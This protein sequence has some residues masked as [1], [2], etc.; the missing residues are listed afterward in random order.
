[1]NEFLEQ[2]LIEGRELV[3]QATEDLLVLEEAPDDRG[4]L[5]SAFR[6]FH[7]LKGLA[8]IVEFAAM[9]RVMHTA[10]DGLAAP[11]QHVTA[12]ELVGR[13]DIAALPRRPWVLP[14]NLQRS[15]S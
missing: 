7:T 13:F 2:F 4:R 6:G 5:D 11:G 1:M 10:E 14:A 12:R 3:E 15:A 8:G 9:A